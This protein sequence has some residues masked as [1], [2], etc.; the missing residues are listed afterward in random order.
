MKQSNVSLKK[1]PDWWTGKGRVCTRLDPQSCLPL[2]AWVPSCKQGNPAPVQGLLQS[3]A[4]SSMACLVTHSCDLQP[5]PFLASGSRLEKS[6]HMDQS[7]VQWASPW[8]LKTGMELS[9]QGRG[10]P[11]T[12]SCGLAFAPQS[13]SLTSCLREETSQVT[14]IG[15][16]HG[17]E[18]MKIVSKLRAC[19]SI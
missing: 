12:G 15:Q 8:L 17:F 6:C 18:F 9:V 5:A 3:C 19:P 10:F 11:V 1:Q 16:H 4:R 14:W 7:K 2:P 13:G